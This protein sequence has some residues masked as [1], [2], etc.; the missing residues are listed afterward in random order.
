MF[1]PFRQARENSSIVEAGLEAELRPIDEHPYVEAAGIDYPRNLVTQFGRYVEFEKAILAQHMADPIDTI[2]GE[3]V[4]GRVPTLI[5]HRFLRLAQADGLIE[6]VPKT[7]FMASGGNH[8]DNPEKRRQVETEWRRNLTSRA[9][10]ILGPVG[11]GNIVVITDTVDK[12]TSIKRIEDAFQ[13]YAGAT[14]TRHVLG[15]GWL[16]GDYST[17]PSRTVVG[18][19]KYPGGAVSHRRSA[20]NG[21]DGKKTGDLRHFL[22]DYTRA[23]Y[24]TVLD[25]PSSRH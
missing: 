10:H 16:R 3:D 4:S 18:V 14:V 8:I 13:H 21:F 25:E 23:L 24:A 15:A 17:N 11:V 2:V 22:D 6:A 19:V 20:Y 9:G 12:G 5:T 1:H 7:R